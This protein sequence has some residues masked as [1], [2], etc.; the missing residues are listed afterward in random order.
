MKTSK[1]LQQIGSI[2]G[3]DMTTEDRAHEVDDI[4]SGAWGGGDEEKRITAPISGELT[5]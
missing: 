3:A 5:M 4:D 1:M 2:G